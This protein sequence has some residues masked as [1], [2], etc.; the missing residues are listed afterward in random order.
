MSRRSVLRPVW[1]PIWAAVAGLGA[2]AAHAQEPAP[3]LVPSTPPPVVQTHRH[4]SHCSCRNIHCLPPAG[5]SLHAFMDQQIGNGVAAQ[6]ML[7]HYDFID[8]AAQLRPRGYR[9]I[10]K[11]QAKL[12]CT[13]YPL[14]IEAS[15]L[16]ELDE[17]RRL[18]VLVAI[19]ERLG[20]AESS[21]RVIVATPFSRGLDGIDAVPLHLRMLRLTI[22]GQPGAGV[23]AAPSAASA[24]PPAR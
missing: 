10:H 4:H 13:P 19:E 17:A 11:L 14:L 9:Q 2:A 24:V 3:L 22:G 18:A 23:L 16:P 5:S 1:G 20:F 12:L 15:G 7:Y 8:D 6:M 21:D